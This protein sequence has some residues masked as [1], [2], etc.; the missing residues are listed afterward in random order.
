M[1]QAAARQPKLDYQQLSGWWGQISNELE[2]GELQAGLCALLC[3]T[4]E[5]DKGRLLEALAQVYEL[6]PHE[7]LLALLDYLHAN[8]LAGLRSWDFSLRILLPDAGVELE[9][10]LRCLRE[11]CQA[12][13]TLFGLNQQRRELTPEAL[14]AL[15]AV[16]QVAAFDY[17]RFQKDEPD[18]ELTFV[19][20]EEGVR[21]AVLLIFSELQGRAGPVQQ[22]Q[23]N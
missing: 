3:L 14:E 19:Q 12:Y 15:Q 1:T 22:Q 7:Q 16:G 21:T 9:Q 5:A 18:A 23:L 8:T 6:E 2:V 13:G 4:P 10:R 17:R 20:L 11:W